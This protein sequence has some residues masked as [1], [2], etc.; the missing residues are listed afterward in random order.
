MKASRKGYISIV[1]LLTEKGANVS[2]KNN[3]SECNV[4]FLT[5]NWY[6]IDRQDCQSAMHIAS[7]PE[8]IVYLLKVIVLARLVTDCL[9]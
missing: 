5:T 3:V 2:V 8:I 7:S 9:I 6:I 4:Q 1:V